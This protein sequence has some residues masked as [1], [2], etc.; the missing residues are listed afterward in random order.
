MTL[1]FTPNLGIVKMYLN[2][3]KR[4]MKFLAP[5]VQKL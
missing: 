2:L 5:V 4:E 3:F 1:V